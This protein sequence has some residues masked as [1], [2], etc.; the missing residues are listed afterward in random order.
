VSEKIRHINRDPISSRVNFSK[1]TLTFFFVVG[2]TL[3]LAMF[4]YFSWKYTN[5]FG[6][7]TIASVS[8]E[9]EKISDRNFVATLCGGEECFW[10]NKY[11]IAFG[12]SGKTGGNLVLIIEDKTNRDLSIGQ[13]LLK[14]ESLA[15][16]LF[17]KKK[18]S[19]DIDVP[20]MYV[21]T[22]DLNLNDFDF[23]TTE[24]WILKITLSENAYRTVETLK[25]TLEEIKKTAPSGISGLDYIDLR[26]SNKVFYKFR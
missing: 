7:S 18:I 13:E 15:E 22:D 26:I 6:T 14:P 3:F 1:K 21:E 24:G 10:L 20:L 17:L 12:K 8:G 19:E 9:T 25:E 11:G 16:L 23:K 5:G 2:G 4:F